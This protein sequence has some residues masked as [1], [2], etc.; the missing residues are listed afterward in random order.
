MANY[1]CEICDKHVDLDFDV[2]HYEHCPFA[3]DLDV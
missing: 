1:Y 3:E 2:E